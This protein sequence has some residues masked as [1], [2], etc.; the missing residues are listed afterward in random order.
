MHKER[1][2]ERGKGDFRKGR[3]M[4]VRLYV[5]PDQPCFSPPPVLHSLVARIYGSHP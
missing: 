4:A 1:T 5:K 3:K 2:I